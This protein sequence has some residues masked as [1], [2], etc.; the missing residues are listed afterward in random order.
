M[1][2]RNEISVG[3][4]P[5]QTREEAIYLAAAVIYTGTVGFPFKA[6]LPVPGAFESARSDAGQY[7][8]SQSA[9]G[10]YDPG[11]SGAGPYEP[12]RPDLGQPSPRRQDMVKIPK[13]VETEAARISPITIQRIKN[14]KT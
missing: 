1:R 8:P 3:E 13:M 12:S 6:I 9:P 5:V 4:F 10:Q 14:A 11:R 7:D 2:G